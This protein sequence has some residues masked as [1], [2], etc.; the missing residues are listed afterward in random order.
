MTG[1]STVLSPSRHV[2]SQLIRL[3][4]VIPGTRDG[5]L[6]D[7]LLKQRNAKRAT[8]NGLEAW[9][10]VAHIF[11]ARPTTKIRVHHLS[12]DRSRANDAD[13]DDEIVE[14]ARLQD[15]KHRHLRSTLDLEDA[16]GVRFAARIV[17][18]GVLGRDRVQRVDRIEGIERIALSN[19]DVTQRFADG[20][21][22]PQPRVH[23][24]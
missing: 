2:T 17:N 19:M 5:Q 10:R 24:L 16:N 8:Q 22:H 14:A 11:L 9:M 20:G 4:R 3:A 12:L 13:L 23:R 6:H 21:Q 7:L 1:K 15:R 18:S